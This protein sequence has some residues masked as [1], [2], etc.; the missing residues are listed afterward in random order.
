MDAVP[1]SQWKAARAAAPTTKSVS[2]TH[3][4]GLFRPWMVG[5]RIR[6]SSR[7]AFQGGPQGAG[8]MTVSLW[9]AGWG[10]V[11][12]SQVGTPCADAVENEKGTHGLRPF[13]A[14]AHGGESVWKEPSVVAPPH[15]DR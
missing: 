9:N 1:S 4:S 7:P 2:V 8:Q 14:L 10:E 6:A 13:A 11:P 12:I 15:D 5:G 3:R